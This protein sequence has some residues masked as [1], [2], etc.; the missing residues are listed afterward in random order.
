ME[1]FLWICLAGAAGTGARYLT[2]VWAAQRF[3]T[4][5][6]YGTLI[7]NLFGC[8]AISAVVHAA[9]TLS[10]SPT[11]RSA[12]TIGFLGG[13]TTYSSFNFET[14]RLLEEGAPSLAALNATL[15]IAGGFVAG[16]L[17]LMCAKQVLGR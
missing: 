5:F 1:R 13:L 17:G 9:L 15:T 14:T 6:P 11:L 8:F 12:M 3:G 2:A 7:V 16:L 4:T 10:W